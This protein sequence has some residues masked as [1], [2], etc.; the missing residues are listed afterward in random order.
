[1]V[2]HRGILNSNHHDSMYVYMNVYV[3]LF[4][5]SICSMVGTPSPSSFLLHLP[6]THLLEVYNLTILPYIYQCISVWGYIA[7]Y[8]II[9]VCQLQIRIC[10]NSRIYIHTYNAPCCSKY[11]MDCFQFGGILIYTMMQIHTLNFLIMDDDFVDIYVLLSNFRLVLSS[12]VFHISIMN[13]SIQNPTFYTFTKR[14]N[15][16]KNTK[17]IWQLKSISTL[18]MCY[19]AGYSL[20]FLLFF[21]RLYWKLS[22]IK[23]R[24]ILS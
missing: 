7:S 18:L 17:L 5:F 22:S 8:Y 19:F 2:N 1:M 14:L 24:F 9:V 21:R 16:C 15:L 11:C 10:C 20:M 4:G 6:L 23:P 3:R 12:V 13:V